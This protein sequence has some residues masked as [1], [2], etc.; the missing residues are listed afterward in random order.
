MVVRFRRSPQLISERR[1]RRAK[2]SPQASGV[3]NVAGRMQNTSP[4][5]ARF[6][7]STR[8]ISE[9]ASGVRNAARRAAGY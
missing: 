1:L 6:R 8:L 3:P 9:R 4:M 5:V 7:R 2:R